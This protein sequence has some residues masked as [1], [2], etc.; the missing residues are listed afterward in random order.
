MAAADS[1]GPVNIESSSTASGG[2]RPARDTSPDEALYALVLGDS[3]ALISYHEPNRELLIR[4]CEHAGLSGPSTMADAADD[5][6]PKTSS[7]ACD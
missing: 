2:S 6:I 4:S 3:I 1:L 5:G 7:P